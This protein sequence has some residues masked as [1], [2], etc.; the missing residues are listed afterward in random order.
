MWDIIVTRSVIE[1]NWLIGKWSRFFPTLQYF[2]SASGIQFYTKLFFHR[3]VTD[4]IF[5]SADLYFKFRNVWLTVTLNP[6]LRLPIC[7]NRKAL[8]YIKALVESEMADYNYCNEIY[9]AHRGWFFIRGSWT[10][11]G[12]RDKTR[13]RARYRRLLLFCPG[14][15]GVTTCKQWPSPTAR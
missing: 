2:I 9:A 3:K 6:T 14:G 8:E 4:E 10:R 5:Q 1:Y 15:R 7:N 12:S 11:A 13:P